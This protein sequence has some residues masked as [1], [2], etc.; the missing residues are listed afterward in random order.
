M[1]CKCGKKS[2]IR[3]MVEVQISRNSSLGWT[4]NIC[5]RCY[6]KIKMMEIIDLIDERIH[7]RAS[8]REQRKQQRKER[9]E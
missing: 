4:R 2:K 5:K 3:I 8:D 9:G 6:N 7:N 1:N